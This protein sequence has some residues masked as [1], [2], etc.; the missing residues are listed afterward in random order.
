V[1]L[2]LQHDEDH[3]M[4]A[5]RHS[6]P[7]MDAYL[8]RTAELPVRDVA[9]FEQAHGEF[10]GNLTDTWIAP[11]EAAPAPVPALE[12]ELHA[13][14]TSL[15]ELE[16]R[17][18]RKGERLEALESEIEALKVARSAALVQ[19][20]SEATAREAAAAKVAEALARADRAEQALGSK[21]VATQ[22]LE[23]R[24]AELAAEADRL[25]T[26]L[27]LAQQLVADKARQLDARAA[28]IASSSVLERKR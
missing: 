18:L 24:G 26:E 15:R 28:E 4:S 7:V 9:A 8:E 10:D 20:E 1:S 14:S 12:A 25:R 17:L 23:A 22:A 2:K 5:T 6:A 21:D 27:R 3:P 11:V 13:V 16:G 19:A